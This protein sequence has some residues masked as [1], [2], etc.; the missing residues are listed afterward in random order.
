MLVYNVRVRVFHLP[1][2]A[3][4]ENKAQMITHV[5]LRYGMRQISFQMDC[6]EM[7]CG[8]MSTN[9]NT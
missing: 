4:R 2:Y 8:E 1:P 9:T 7:M 3:L 5:C 6:A